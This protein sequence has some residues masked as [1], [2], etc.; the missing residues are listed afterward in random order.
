M[1]ATTYYR[2]LTIEYDA[3]IPRLMID[4]VQVPLPESMKQ[5]QVSALE[6]RR[7]ALVEHA[8]GCVD[9]LPS[10]EHRDR[11]RNNHV[12]ILQEGAGQWNAWRLR[13]PEIRPLL[14]DATLDGFNLTGVNLANANMIRTHLRQANL[15][16]SNFHEANLGGADLS[17]AIL[18]SAHFCR[19]DLYETILAG[20][21]LDSANLQGTQ[22][23]KTDLRGA[24]LINCRIYGIA[25]WD[26]NIDE[27]HNRKT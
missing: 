25:A 24:K 2:G 1:A 5:Q 16:N 21:D 27:R 9:A 26:L 6:V 18:R 4:G 10:I 23:A 17:H 20:A 12:S 14:Y 22:L 15:S 8:R 3:E 7:A 13:N 19:T 11:V